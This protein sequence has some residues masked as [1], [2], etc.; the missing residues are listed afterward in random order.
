M[1][2]AVL[3]TQFY[4][5]SFEP[6][7]HWIYNLENNLLKIISLPVMVIVSAITNL[8]LIVITG[9]CQ[10][11]VLGLTYVLIQLLMVI[12][13]I[14]IILPIVLI[15]LITDRG[16]NFLFKVELVSIID[17]FTS[18]LPS[19]LLPSFSLFIWNTGKCILIGLPI[20]IAIIAF[21]WVTTQ[22]L[23][24]G[25]LMA[26]QRLTESATIFSVATIILGLCWKLSI[27]ES[28]VRY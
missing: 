17:F 3:Y 7:C 28:I 26:R 14:L 4:F 1:Y 10:L 2:F 15:M 21:I 19:N 20:A 22:I 8:I 11:L 23:K 18:H 16:L 24:L 9:G 12:G 25:W 6:L 5:F 13:L 27:I